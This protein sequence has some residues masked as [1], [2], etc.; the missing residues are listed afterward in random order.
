[1]NFSVSNN[2]IPC[3][4]V[5]APLTVLTFAT[6]AACEFGAFFRSALVHGLHP[7]L[8]GWGSPVDGL[9]LQ[10]K[11]HAVAE[12]VARYDPSQLVL[13]ADAF[14]VLFLDGADAILDTY[15]RLGRPLVFGA[16]KGCYPD[17]ALE[18]EYP[19]APTPWRFLNSGAYMGPA[20]CVRT[21]LAE[22][23]AHPRAAEGAMDQEL[24]ALV[25]LR[26][27]SPIA[28]DHRCELFMNLHLS[29]H[30]IV[31]TNG[32]P[33]NRVTGTRPALLHFNG[34]AKRD[35][36]TAVRRLRL[37][38][39]PIDLSPLGSLERTAVAAAC[40]AGP[41]PRPRPMG[42]RLE[43]LAWTVRSTLAQGRASLARRPLR[44]RVLDAAARRGL[45]LNRLRGASAADL[46][47]R[48]VYRRRILTSP[49]MA[50]EAPGADVIEVHTLT[51][52]IDHLGTLWAVKT[53]LGHA[54]LRARVVLHD[55]GTLSPRVRARLRHHLPG[56]TIVAPSD[57]ARAI[58][59]LLSRYPE[60]ARFRDRAAPLSRKILDIP[61][62]STSGRCIILDSDVLFFQR[63]E[64]LRGYVSAGIPCF[65][66]DGQ[67]AYSLP[68]D[69]LERH[70][71]AP[72]VDRLNS[73]LLHIT[74]DMVILDT[75][76]AFLRAAREHGRM[77]WLGRRWLEQTAWAV[78]FSQPGR[79]VA[80]LGPEYQI[81][82]AP[83]DDA[84]VAHH[85]PNDGSRRLFYDQG[86]RRLARD[87]FLGRLPQLDRQ[88]TPLTLD[89]PGAI[90]VDGGTNR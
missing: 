61:L 53:L 33:C 69:T 56:A 23:L 32:R 38:H 84:T 71:G 11:A 81:S 68:L 12:E 57:A 43:D 65:M 14:D 64:R 82:Y 40:P 76:E 52:E 63:P 35:I 67:R 88:R 9:A 60:C 66:T 13:F 6:H 8:L 25:H 31:W 21:A 89:T 36:R 80:R 4:L 39:R 48:N 18:D 1:M 29:Q 2:L 55:D 22:M 28:L 7:R 86:L 46:Y 47:Y 87:G 26:G 15:T 78:L 45:V 24:A 44:T 58:E 50:C 19:E 42:D 72:V 77:S 16:E 41:A 83:I 70:T 62:L 59:P 54:G 37:E 3:G 30:D 73:G 5:A 20:G 27:R 34:N 51:C 17:G 49:P 90:A 75:L 85:F 10:R 79:M 74:R